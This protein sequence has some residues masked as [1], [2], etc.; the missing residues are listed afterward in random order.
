MTELTSTPA[1]ADRAPL[2]LSVGTLPPEAA[3]SQL[4][5]H[6]CKVRMSDLFFT[7]EENHV[8]VLGRHLGT[9]HPV[10]KLAADHG[11]RCITH[12]KVMSNM[13]LAERRR[14]LDGR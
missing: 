14:P 11:R 8:S 3:V 7:T 2:T 13:D 4:I 6:A 1:A 5:A 10:S 9:M 12:I